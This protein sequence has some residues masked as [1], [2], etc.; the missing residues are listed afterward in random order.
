MRLFHELPELP[1]ELGRALLSVPLPFL[2]V[3]EKF[4]FRAYASLGN[5]WVDQFQAYGLP[6]NDYWYWQVGVVTSAYGLDFT[7]AYTDTNIEPEGCGA[8]PTTAPA[9]S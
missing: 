7:V 9:S 5:F 4:S 6:T 8:S 3:H 1:N 2:H